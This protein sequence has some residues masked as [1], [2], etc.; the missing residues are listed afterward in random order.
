MRQ[1]LEAA[2][3]ATRTG[4]TIALATIVRAQGSTPRA[5]G[6]KMLV[7][8]DGTIKGTIGGGEME[9]RVIEEARAALESGQPRMV[10]YTFREVEQGDVGVCGG[11]NDVFIDILGSSK[12]LLIVG[13]GHVGQ[14]VARLGEFLEMA[15]IV[16]DTRPEY[17]NQE[18]FPRARQIIVGEIGQELARYPISRQSY[19]VIVTRGHLQDAEALAAVIRSP[20]PYIGMIG[21]RRKTLRVFE[22]M[23]AQGI[24]QALLNRVHAPIGLEIGAET[25]EEIAVSILGQIIAT[26]HG[27]A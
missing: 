21:S 17:A 22:M 8:R 24:E 23:Q 15:C 27:R 25:P 9:R 7:L 19:I 11:E 3:E 14:A 26:M 2:L 4:E 20:A 13:A 16:F 5:T 10:H 1:L 12:E 6:A 18:R